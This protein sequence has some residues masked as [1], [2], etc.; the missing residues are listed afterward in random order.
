[1][2]KN[3]YTF[4]NISSHEYIPYVLD[5]SGFRVDSKTI[6]ELNNIEEI[7]NQLMIINEKRQT[8]LTNLNEESSRSHLIFIF[9]IET[10]NG[11]KLTLT[12]ADF[13]GLEPPL[14][15]REFFKKLTTY[16]P[17]NDILM[18]LGISLINYYKEDKNQ[19]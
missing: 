12:V 16:N 2:Y 4:K 9:E 10:N 5:E 8:K 7:N 15:L 14:D 11:V 19:I 1:M 3:K 18:L 17:T 6:N 13:A